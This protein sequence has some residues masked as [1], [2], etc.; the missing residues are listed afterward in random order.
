MS[1][2]GGGPGAYV[3]VGLVPN[4]V[5]LD[6]VI[7]SLTNAFTVPGTI[8][9]DGTQDPTSIY[10]TT[11]RSIMVAQW[12]SGAKDDPETPVQFSLNFLSELDDSIGPDVSMGPWV[13]ASDF[14]IGPVRTVPLVCQVKNPSAQGSV[15]PVQIVNPSVNNKY[16]L[17]VSITINKWPAP[18]AYID[19]G[20]LLPAPSPGTWFFELEGG[21]NT[22][23]AVPVRWLDTYHISVKYE[24]ED[25]E[26]YGVALA[27]STTTVNDKSC[28][29]D[30][31]NAT[32][33]SIASCDVCEASDNKH[34]PE[35]MSFKLTGG[36][37]STV[38]FTRHDTSL[39]GAVATVSGS[40]IPVDDS[41]E[42]SVVCVH[43]KKKN[44]KLLNVVAKIGDVIR[45][46]WSKHHYDKG[47]KITC[48][49]TWAGGLKKQEI[50]IFT[51]CMS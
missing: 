41:G 30:L 22:T 5:D 16:K 1:S 38:S 11:P 27:P 19:G 43:Q 32:P 25:G 26:Q 4:N 17:T 12:Q 45:T 36:G 48:A 33:A 2:S 50:V 47:Y 3:P 44:K 34:H 23:M 20:P 8:Q 39:A 9:A 6:D 18:S 37:P 46:S 51:N 28:G 31:E 15:F 10:V 13:T 29:Q 40:D 35:E 21:A 24:A 49:I 42:F 14:V 7:A